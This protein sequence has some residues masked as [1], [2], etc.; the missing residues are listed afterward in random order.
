MWALNIG[1][2]PI[3]DYSL[4]LRVQPPLL[5]CGSSV[6]TT[7]PASGQS[8][9]WY[10]MAVLGGGSKAIAS[11]NPG[12]RKYKKRKTNAIKTEIEEVS[13]F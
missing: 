11:P 8:S 9:I 6:G 1:S 2:I 10:I 7:E 12:S 13:I 3:Y 5:Y 4:G